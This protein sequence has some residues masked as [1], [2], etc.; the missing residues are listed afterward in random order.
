M[1]DITRFVWGLK[2]KI[3]RFIVTG[4]YDLDIVEEAFD[5][6]LDINSTFKMLVNANALCFKCDGYEH[7]DYQCSLKSRHVSTVS[8]DV[9]DS[10]VIEDVYVPFKPASI[11]ED[12]SVGS[13]ILIINEGHASYEG[14]SEVVNAIVES[15]TPLDVDAHAY[16]ISESALELAESSVSSQI[17]RYLFVTPLIEDDI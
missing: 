7:F 9:D 12:I 6:V 17:F 10:K 2:S 1:R 15:I 3:K 4:S 14:I 13:D 11:I 8:S 5:V 16:D